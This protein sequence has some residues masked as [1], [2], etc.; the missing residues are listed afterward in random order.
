MTVCQLP[1]DTLINCSS[2]S[3]SFLVRSLSLEQR[4]PTPFIHTMAEMLSEIP[5]SLNVAQYHLNMLP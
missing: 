2:L 5:L 1:H 4:S 3:G